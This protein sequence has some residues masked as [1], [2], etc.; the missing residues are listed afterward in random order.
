MLGRDSEDG[1]LGEGRDGRRL[2]TPVQLLPG[3][4]GVYKM[5]ACRFTEP[6]LPDPLPQ[7]QQQQ[8]LQPPSE[9]GPRLCA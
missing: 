6:P 8:F 1:E 5:G 2:V 7:Q 3:A 4:E 9:D